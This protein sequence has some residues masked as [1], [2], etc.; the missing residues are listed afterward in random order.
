MK[1]KVFGIELCNM[2]SLSG[3]P[4]TNITRHVGI[5]VAFFHSWQTQNKTI[6]RFFCNAELLLT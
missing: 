6:K 1:N 2:T 5:Y 3:K 4:L